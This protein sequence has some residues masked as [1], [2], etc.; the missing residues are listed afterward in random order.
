MR[1]SIAVSFVASVLAGCS[2]PSDACDGAL[3]VTLRPVDTTL[4]VGQQFTP[5]ALLSKCQPNTSAWSAQDT[6]I[7]RV[8]PQSGLTTAIAPGRTQL[9]VTFAW[10]TG[11]ADVVTY[12]RVL[13]PTVTVR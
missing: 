11:R 13:G 6:T 9:S 5:Q 1:A 12:G 8:D 3:G 7:V 10:S 2:S 4:V